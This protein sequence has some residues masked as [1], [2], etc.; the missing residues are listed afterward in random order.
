MHASLASSVENIFKSI[1]GLET[2]LE[3]SS[4][5]ELEIGRMWEQL[6]WLYWGLLR[7]DPSEACSSK[8][9]AITPLAVKLFVCSLI[10]RGG[11]QLPGAGGAL[12]AASVVSPTS[13]AELLILVNQGP[14]PGTARPLAPL[15]I[16]D[17]VGEGRRDVFPGC[18]L[19]KVSHC[20]SKQFTI[21]LNE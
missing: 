15:L 12:C 8:F 16:R 3:V 21:T 2:W 6:F 13:E 11:V 17:E 18:L 10:D 14:A 4:V 19:V 20:G 1:V 5:Q 9:S 7:Y